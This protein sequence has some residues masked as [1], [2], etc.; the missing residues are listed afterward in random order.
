MGLLRTFMQNPQ[1]EVLAGA[2]VYEVKNER[3]GMRVKELYSDR[4]ETVDVKLYTDYRKLLENPEIDAVVIASPDHWHA[5]MAIHACEAGKDIY[6]EKPL[7]Y[8]VK[9][10]QD[11]IKAVRDNNIVLATGSMQRSGANFQHAVRMVQKGYL[12]KIE[13]VYANV[14]DNPFPKEVDYQAETIPEGLDWKAWLGPRPEMPYMPDLNPPISISPQKNEKAWGAWRWYKNTGGGLMTDWGAHMFDIAQWGI[15][16]DRN[17]PVSIIPDQGDQP[18]KY[19]YASGIE[20]LVASYDGQ[21]KGVK[22]IGEKG[23]ISVSRGGYDTSVD[24]C[25][26]KFSKEELS[27]GAHHIDFIDSVIMRKDPIAPVEVGHSTCTVCTIGNIAHELGRE[28]T[29]D[30]INQTFGDDWEAQTKLHYTYETDF[31]G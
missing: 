24:E 27:F 28:L 8:T 14:G 9:E 12:G 1:V 6:L 2:D 22:F 20:M 31:S 4:G 13:T 3:F 10:G 25:K 11:L 26:R 21:K 16:M 19:I 18:L 5:L 23:W 15:G 29:W 7:T 17:G 30:P